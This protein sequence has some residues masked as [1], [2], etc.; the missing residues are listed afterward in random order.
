[1]QL[2]KYSSV[3]GKDPAIVKKLANLEAE[4]GHPDKA[5]AALKRLNYIY[6]QDEELHHKLG[7]LLLAQN[8]AA[9]AVREF[10]AVIALKPI[11]QADAHFEL[12]RALSAAKRKDEA[13]DQVV[14]ALEAAPGFKPAQKLLLELSQ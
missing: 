1:A 9:G 4:A 13:R 12:A 10:Q 5:A 11:N 3:G 6:P 14:L 7:E 2:E 8:D